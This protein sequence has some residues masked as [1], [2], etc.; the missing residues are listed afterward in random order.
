MYAIIQIFIECRVICCIVVQRKIV[1]L[2]IIIVIFSIRFQASTESAEI[3]ENCVHICRHTC[4][5]HKQYP[6]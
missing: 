6:Y 3:F 4:I 5:S 1:S 2:V